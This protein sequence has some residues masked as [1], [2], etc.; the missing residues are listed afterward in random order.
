MHAETKRVFVGNLPPDATQT[1]IRKRFSKFGRVLSVEIKHRSDSSAFAFLDFQT[2]EDKLNS[3]KSC[4]YFLQI[5]EA[6]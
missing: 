3:C 6:F 4:L 5:Y 2:D 1:D